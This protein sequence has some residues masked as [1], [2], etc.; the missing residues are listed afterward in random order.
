MRKMIQPSILSH[1]KMKEQ[2]NRLQVDELHNLNYGVYGNPSGQTILFVHGGPGLGVKLSDLAFFDLKKHN[3]ILFD[4]RGCGK[5]TP[6]G[7]LRLNTTAKLIEDIEKIIQKTNKKEIFLFGGSWG[8]T[9]SLLFAIK[10]PQKVKGMILRGLFTSTNEERKHFENGGTKTNFPQAWSRFKSFVPNKFENEPS[11]FYFNQI[12][13]GNKEEQE[14]FS[15]ELCFYGFSVSR[16]TTESSNEKNEFKKDEY[17]SKAKILSHYSINDFF[18]PEGYIE[19]NMKN[20][21]HIPI[22]IVQGIH[23]E[24]TLASWAKRFSSKFKN[25]NLIEVDAGHSANE[26]KMK[27]QLIRSTKEMINKYGS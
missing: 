11:E 25:I 23:D 26:K 3:V 16:K 24:I 6:K 8:S 27:L 19:Q 9:L 14:K 18:L 4:Q 2:E 13:N 5:S 10:N 15:H 7:E 17:L 22:T 12:L 20:I 1:Q 21:L